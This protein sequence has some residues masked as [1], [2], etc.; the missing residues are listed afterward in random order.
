MPSEIFEIGNV[1]DL[2]AIP[3]FLSLRTIHYKV[4]NE[5]SSVYAVTVAEGAFGICGMPS[6]SSPTLACRVALARAFVYKLSLL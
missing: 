3:T 5:I 4:S 2:L 6:S 1:W